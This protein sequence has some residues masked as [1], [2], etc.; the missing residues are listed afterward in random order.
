[1]RCDSHLIPPQPPLP[2]AYNKPPD[3]R[4]HKP[5]AAPTT[6]STMYALLPLLPFLLLV[7]Y[8]LPRRPYLRGPPLLSVL[9]PGPVR[10]F[11]AN[12]NRLTECLSAISRTHGEVFA[13]WLGLS[14][15][16]FTTD[17]ADMVHMSSDT[18]LFPRAPRMRAIFELA[19]PGGIFAMSHEQHRVVRAALHRNFNH[20]MLRGFHPAMKR[21]VDTLCE[22]LRRAAAA[23]KPVDI[24]TLL[25]STTF[26]II[27]NVA[28][29]GDFSP[30]DCLKF[31]A[32]ID[33]LSEELMLEYVQYWV[34]A[35]FE[36]AGSRARLFACKK[37]IYAMCNQFVQR[38][39]AETRADKEARAPD[40]LDTILSLDQV[41]EHELASLI[42][43][44]AIAGSYTTSQTMTWSLYETCCVPRAREAVHEEL[45]RK[46]GG[47]GADEMLSFEEVDTL[48]YVRNVWKEST[49]LHPISPLLER[50]V[51]ED[52]TLKGT[53]VRL[54]KGTIL[55]GNIKRMQTHPGIWSKADEFRP[56]RW[57]RRGIEAERV[58]FGAY[59]AFALG[60]IKCVGRFLAD[61]EGPLIIAE[62]HR[63]FKFQL[64]C[65]KDEVVNRSNFVDLPRYLNKS[66]GQEE[67]IPMYVEL[68]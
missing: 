40:M 44:F 17:P 54:P 22:A 56:E 19:V 42:V 18:R 36:W 57:G 58:P 32:D 67:G 7:L 14:R 15:V 4:R 33:I 64:A 25:S 52:V 50:V 35:A 16:V 6:S 24:S 51:T 23:G 63:R 10:T 62:L 46:F 53:G 34:R 39:L 66:T 21:A 65:E 9:L 47:K 55:Y 68:R 28:F 13:L 31:A 30:A 8:L 41:P 43:E 26:M 37:R 45:A 5:S 49:R 29:G 48:E 38:R 1:M 3:P 2:P 60:K 27:L 61:Y 20:S 59:A 11:H 12:P